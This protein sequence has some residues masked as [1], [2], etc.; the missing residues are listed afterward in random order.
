LGQTV[1]SG[2][3]GDV[4]LCRHKATGCLF[5]L[6]KIFK[7]V[8]RDYGMES[9]FALELK[10]LYVLDHPNIVKLYGHFQDEYHVF[11]LMEYL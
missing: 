8:I 1:G 4:Y 5:A 3:F 7:S 10:L 2:K 6:K 11:L 9:Q